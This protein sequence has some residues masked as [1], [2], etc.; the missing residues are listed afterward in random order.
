MTTFPWIQQLNINT[1]PNWQTKTF[2]KMFLN[3]EKL[4]KIQYQEAGLI[5]T[6]G[7]QWE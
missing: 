6:A 7:F 1:D 2:T 5:I 4:E 3:M